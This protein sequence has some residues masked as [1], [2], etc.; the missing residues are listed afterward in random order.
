MIIAEIP[1]QRLEFIPKP[2]QPREPDRFGDADLVP[3]V[4]DVLTPFVKIFNTRLLNGVGEALP[5]LFIDAFD[6]LSQCREIVLMDR[7]LL[8]STSC[9]TN[10]PCHCQHDFLL[11]KPLCCA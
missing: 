5:A 4:F 7:P 10:G 3:K 11:L 8:H 2:L 6:S 1:S 9:R